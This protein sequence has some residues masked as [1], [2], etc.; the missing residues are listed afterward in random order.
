MCISG[1]RNYTFLSFL[2]PE[3]FKILRTIQARLKVGGAYKKACNPFQV[4]VQAKEIWICFQRTGR[5]R[6][7]F[8]TMPTQFVLG[9]AAYFDA[10]F[11]GSRKFSGV[12]PKNHEIKSGETVLTASHR[13]CLTSC[14]PSTLLC[15]VFWSSGH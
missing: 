3:I 8:V 13:R 6:L 5:V 2:E 4:R 7:F 1:F 9:L 10:T 14:L 11:S 12:S 15:Y